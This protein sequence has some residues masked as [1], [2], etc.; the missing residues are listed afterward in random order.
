MTRTRDPQGAPLSRAMAQTLLV[1]SLVEVIDLDRRLQYLK[2]VFRDKLEST[3]WKQIVATQAQRQRAISVALA[4][5]DTA[6]VFTVGTPTETRA[7]Q[8]LER[9]DSWTLDRETMAQRPDLA[10][11][12]REARR[13]ARHRQRSDLD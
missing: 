2:V 12:E 13:E 10:Q 8:L 11:A 7:R 9:N 3:T 1:S 4:V 6:A 5:W